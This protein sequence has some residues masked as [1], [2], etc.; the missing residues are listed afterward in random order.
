MLAVHSLCPGAVRTDIGR[1]APRLL[2]PALDLTMRA[3]FQSPER[4]AQPVVYLAC[5]RAME[6]E[7]GVYL[8]TT[9]RREPSDRA[10]D[11]TLGARLWDAS[12]RLLAAHGHPLCPADLAAA[13]SKGPP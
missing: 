6:G 11:P 3:F 7:T 10:S 12:G 5:S 13:G 2:K 9:R 8:H 4:A 1:E